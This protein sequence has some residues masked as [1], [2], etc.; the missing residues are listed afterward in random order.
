MT[1]KERI[2]KYVCGIG[3]DQCEN[4]GNCDYDIILGCGLNQYDLCGEC[5]YAY[6]AEKWLLNHID[7][8]KEGEI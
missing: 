8:V 4:A 1:G 2:E 7:K 5:Q 3:P 6:D